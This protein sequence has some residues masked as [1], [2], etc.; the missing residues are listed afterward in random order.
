MVV[1]KG[2]CLGKYFDDLN[3]PT[4]NNET[5]WCLFWRGDKKAELLEL[6]YRINK[7][8]RL[9]VKTGNS[10]NP[11]ENGLLVVRTCLGSEFIP[12]GLI[13]NCYFQQIVINCTHPRTLN[14]SRALC[15]TQLIS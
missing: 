12:C 1:M 6:K 15:N 13:R 9:F 7:V 3:H 2:G 8:P 11:G 5:V 10:M 14:M 4:S